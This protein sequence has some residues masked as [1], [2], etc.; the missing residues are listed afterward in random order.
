VS[1]VA[2]AL[3]CCDNDFDCRDAWLA[4]GAA[5]FPRYRL[6][7][8]FER[9]WSQ[10]T[11]ST[12]GIASVANGSFSI[13]GQLDLFKED[14]GQVIRYMSTGFPSSR[15]A[16]VEC[17]GHH[18]GMNGDTFDYEFNGSWVMNG[19]LQCQ[20]GNF[21]QGGCNPQ[22]VFGP[23]RANFGAWVSLAGIYFPLAGPLTW[24]VAGPPAYSGTYSGFALEE[25]FS[26][27]AGM[28][29]GPACPPFRCP[30]GIPSAPNTPAF[31]G[32]QDHRGS[33]YAVAAGRPTSPDFPDPD[34][35]DAPPGPRGMSPY[36]RICP[37]F[38]GSYQDA[39]GNLVIINAP[40]WCMT[41]IANFRGR[42]LSHAI[43][44]G[45]RAPMDPFGGGSS[46][47]VLGSDLAAISLTPFTY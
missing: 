45:A 19:R 16:N 15:R 44:A 38:G 17:R 25:A 6:A 46:V 24:T 11:F 22:G 30:Q 29:N 2:S 32:C 36:A 12:S 5:N 8:S 34:D 41:S 33:I 39:G 18:Q 35:P 43:P 27:G 10:A 42:N 9:E 4:C 21:Q 47:L 31:G 23:L 26:L 28:E 3:C 14:Y 1:A 40:D 7:F 20:Y 13:S 37:E